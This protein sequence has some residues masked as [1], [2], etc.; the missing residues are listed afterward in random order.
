VKTKKLLRKIVF[1]INPVP[2][3]EPRVTSA[4]CFYDL[5]IPKYFSPREKQLASLLIKTGTEK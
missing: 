1:K 4:L 3:P 2:A 5:P